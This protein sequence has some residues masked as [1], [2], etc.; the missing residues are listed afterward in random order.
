MHWR[1]YFTFGICPPMDN[2]LCG[3]IS[4]PGRK[5]LLKTK[6]KEYKYLIR[7]YLKYRK[8]TQLAVLK[9]DH[10]INFS[11]HFI[12]LDFPKN[13]QQKFVNFYCCFTYYY[14]NYFSAQ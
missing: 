12:G 4:Y 7:P 9:K 6:N 5:D 1:A 14:V 10:N 2:A 13:W 3:H 8:K 11:L